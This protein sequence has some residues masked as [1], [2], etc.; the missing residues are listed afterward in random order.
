MPLVEI[1]VHAELPASATDKLDQILALVQQ[2][3]KQEI[4]I[5]ADLSALEAEVTREHDVVASAVT[6]LQGLK[7]A[8]DA[9]G[10]DPVKLEAL[11][12]SLASDTDALAAAVVANT[13]AAPTT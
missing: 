6:L 10:T 13:P 2:I 12:A 1:H 8:L 7:A 4:T 5:M 3:A 11:R 9:A